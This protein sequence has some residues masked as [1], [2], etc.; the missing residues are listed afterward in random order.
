MISHSRVS[1]RAGLAVNRTA[2]AKLVHAIG[3]RSETLELG[4]DAETD[5]LPLL[6]R[7]QGCDG[8]GSKTLCVGGNG[9]IHKSEAFLLPPDLG[10]DSARLHESADKKTEEIAVQLFRGHY[11]SV[12]STGP[13]VN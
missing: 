3:F 6:R 10:E 11:T 12:A 1:P 5:E 7:I 2:R 9:R 4:P 8:V 13:P